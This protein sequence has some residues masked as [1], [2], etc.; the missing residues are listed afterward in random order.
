MEIASVVDF[1]IDLLTYVLP[2]CFLWAVTDK[3]VRVVVKT[4]TGKDYGL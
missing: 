4:A 1:L 3:V 2:A